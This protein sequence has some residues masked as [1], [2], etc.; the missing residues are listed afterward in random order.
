MLVLTQAL[1]TSSQAHFL[2][3]HAEKSLASA[4]EAKRRGKILSMGVGE[5]PTVRDLPAMATRGNYKPFSRDFHCR[6][7]KVCCMRILGGATD[8]LDGGPSQ[9]VCLLKPDNLLHGEILFSMY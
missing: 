7:E 5:T 1:L 8:K 2:L 9:L 6:Y 3:L 4:R